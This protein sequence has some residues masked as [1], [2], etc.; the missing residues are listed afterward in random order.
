[1]VKHENG[2]P[3]GCTLDRN[4]KLKENMRERIKG[5]KIHKTRRLSDLV[6][7]ILKSKVQKGD[8]R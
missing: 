2:D 4:K 3:S 1:M 5:G 7:K 6:V 8:V